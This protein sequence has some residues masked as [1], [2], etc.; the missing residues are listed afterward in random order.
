VAQLIAAQKPDAQGG[1]IPGYIQMGSALISNP[2]GEHEPLNIVVNEIVFNAANAT[3]TCCCLICAGV[4]SLSVTA[5]PFTVPNG[6]ATQLTATATYNSGSKTDVTSRASWSSNNTPV[7]TVS[8]GLVSGVSPGQVTI[9]AGFAAEAGGYCR[10]L[11]QQC[12]I[13]SFPGSSG[14]AVQPTVSISGPTD[15]PL[16]AAGSS[17]PNS[18]TLT[19]TGDPSG[20]AYSWATSSSKVSLSNTTSAAVTVTSAA[21]SGSVGDVPITI[22]YTLNG[23]SGTATASITVQQPTSMEVTSDTAPAD[24]HTCVTTRYTGPLCPESTYSGGANYTSYLRT[25]VYQV[26]DELNHPILGFALADLESYTQ[27]TGSCLV[28][29]QTGAGTGTTVTDCFF[30]CSETCRT[31]ESCSSSAT[32]TITGNG[33]VVRTENVTWTCSGATLSP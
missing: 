15:V 19:A 18:I 8:S 1:V 29:I 10:N 11:G 13:F 22:T 6:S 3:C 30:L 27:P 4:V 14:G 25:R 28:T 23:A 26:M 9:T 33:Y 20:G 32:Q 31:G 12:P 5:N 7:A 21:A 17:G 16:R 2:A 24:G